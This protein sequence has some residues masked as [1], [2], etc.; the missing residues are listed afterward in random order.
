MQQVSEATQR[1]LQRLFDLMGRAS[2]FSPRDRDAEIVRL[3]NQIAD[4]GEPGAIVGAAGCLFSPTV[5]VRTAASRAIHCLLGQSPP[6]QLLHLGDVLGGPYGWYISDGWKRLEP[7]D[8]RAWIGEESTRTSVLGLLSFHH[9]GYVRQ[10]AVRLLAQVHDG[11]ELP[12]LLIRQNDWVE[13]IRADARGAVQARLNEAYVP[14]FVANLPLVIHL[15]AFRRSDHSDLVRRIVGMLVQP[16]HDVLL[17]QA[18]H[19]PGRAVRRSVVR[20]ALEAEK[21]HRPR[22]V[23]HALASPDG[24]VRLW[25]SR[26]VGSCFSGELL[27]GVLHSLSRDGFMPVRRE[28]LIVRA[29]TSR[30]S[31]RKLWHQALLDGHQSMRELARF[32]LAKLGEVDWA[33]VYRQALMEQPDSL[34]ALAGLGETGDSSDLTAI[35]TYLKSPLPSRRRAAVIACAQL[36]GENFV[37]DLFECLQDASPAV[38]REVRKRLGAFASSLDGERLCRVV[39]EDDRPDVRATALRLI[40]ALGKWRSLPWLIRASVHQDP[41]TAHL[42]QRLLT[43]WFTPPKCNRVFTRPSLLDQR[44]I[45]AALA[46][47]REDMEKAFVRKLE[48]YLGEWVICN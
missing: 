33:G 23:A 19:S 34:A 45:A 35:R 14:H 30:D 37:A 2:W 22:V 1:L 41:P 46:K 20:L 42:A 25:G 4:Q 31:G 26:H 24:V 5:E 21:E 47:T 28:A 32:H 36:G 40:D 12:Y 13:P 44:A 17:A 43:A 6:E 7:A 39:M 10:A 11:S 8:L 38:V 15:L 27:E 9:N 16:E 18:I 48:S 29:A 3:L